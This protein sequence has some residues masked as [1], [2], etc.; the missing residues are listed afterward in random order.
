MD[1]EL[2][3]RVSLKNPIH[4][5]ALGF[6]TGL[7]PFM[8]GTIGT[9][10]ALPIIFALS[11]AP[12]LW[13]YLGLTIVCCVIGFWLCDVTAKDMRVHDDSS[14]VWDEVAGMMITMVAIPVNWQTLLAGFVLFRL[15]DIVKPWPISYLDKHVQGGVGIMLDDIVAGLMA[16]LA[17]HLIF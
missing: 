3:T 13:L 17:M 9:L 4:L 5:L 2:R 1:A 8:P 15:F 12:S 6:G 14:I 10:V 11:F 7:A 16:L